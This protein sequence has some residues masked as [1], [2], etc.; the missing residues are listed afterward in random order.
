MSQAKVDRYKE[1]KKNRKQILK[2]EKR[3]RFFGYSAAAL[4]A[5]CI[6]GWAGYSVYQVYEDNKPE[7]YTKVDMTALN[8]YYTNMEGN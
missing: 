3:N 8:D 2:R 1:L 5:L 6:A 7:T 4:I